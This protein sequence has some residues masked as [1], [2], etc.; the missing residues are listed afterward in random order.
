M[1]HKSRNRKVVTLP[2]HLQ[3]LTKSLE[4]CFFILLNST[5]YARLFSYLAIWLT[6][7]HVGD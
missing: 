4:F 5:S 3:L 1:E 7:G 2:P 6:K